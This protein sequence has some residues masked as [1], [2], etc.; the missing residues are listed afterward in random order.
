MRMNPKLLEFLKED[1]GRGDIT[2][3]AVIPEDKI[4]SAHIIVN[5]DGVLAGLEECM[6]L[7]K[8]YNLD[9]KSEFKDGDNIK[10][11][12]IILKIRGVAKKILTLERLLL[13]LLMSMSGIATATNRLVEKCK[14][15]K[16]TIAG[17]RKTTPGFRYFEKKAIQIGGGWPHRYSLDE[18]YLIKDNHTALVGLEE[19][20]K[21]AR[22][23]E[24]SKILEVEV[25]TLEDAIKAC[26][27][28][29]DVL[30]L[31]NLSPEETSHIVKKIEKRGLR[32]QVKIE[33]SGGITEKNIESYTNIKPDI[34][35]IGAITTNNKWL[36]M[37]MKIKW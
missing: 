1:V 13:N 28:G 5:E 26:E 30:M 10:K 20:I 37:S 19:A 4:A 27:L 12:D 33:L 23:K 22:E 6:E 21:K 16:I 17:T 11:G 9:F 15:Y 25:S 24:P 8:Y 18:A 2:T 35:S 31:D 36:D 32:D 29:V 14:N 3:E 7:L 34:I